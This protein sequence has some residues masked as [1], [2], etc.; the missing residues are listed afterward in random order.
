MTNDQTPR[1]IG[2]RGRIRDAL[3]M[4]Q[5]VFCGESGVDPSAYNR[6]EK[7]GIAQR[8]S[9]LMRSATRTGE[10]RLIYPRDKTGLRLDLARA[11]DAFEG[12]S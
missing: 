12:V 11:I 3:G 5:A 2:E 6:F 8:S 10:V 4:M 9:P 7:R 1:A